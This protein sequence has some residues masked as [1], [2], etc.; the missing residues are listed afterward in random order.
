MMRNAICGLLP[1]AH[2]GAALYA[3]FAWVIIGGLLSSTLLARLVTPVLY[4]VLSPAVETTNES[5]TRSSA[6]G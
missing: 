5:I 6:H 2:Q 3:S 4:K 1:I